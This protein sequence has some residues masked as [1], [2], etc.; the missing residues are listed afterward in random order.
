MHGG[1]SD[2]LTLTLLEPKVISLC[3][4]YIEPGQPAQPCSL[5]R[6]YTVGSS[7][8]SSHIYI[9]KNDNGQCQKCKMDYSISA[10]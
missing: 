8:S 7:A 5:T 2:V 6:L 9:P 10:W 1:A 4:Q 3:H